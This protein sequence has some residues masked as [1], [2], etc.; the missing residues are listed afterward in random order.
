MTDLVDLLL[1]WPLF[2]TA[3]VV[4]GVAPGLVLRVIVL[5][6]PRSH[7]RR[8]ELFAELYVV[9]YVERPWFVAQHLERAVFDG[10]AARKQAAAQRRRKAEPAIVSRSPDGDWE[11]GIEELPEIGGDPS[12]VVLLFLIGLALLGSR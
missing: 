9:P 5:A 4:F 2:V 10:T 1:D 8:R 12:L 11:L 6:Y 3:L 7:P